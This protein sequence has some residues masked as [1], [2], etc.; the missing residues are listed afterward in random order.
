MEVNAFLISPE[1]AEAG[2]WGTFLEDARVRI[3]R[4]NSQYVREWI[5]NAGHDPA[6]ILDWLDLA[7]ADRTEEQQS[8]IV[9]LIE[10]ALMADWEGF[11]SEGASVEFGDRGLVVRDPRASA[12]RAWAVRYSIRLSPYTEAQ[13]AAVGGK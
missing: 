13:A 10:H 4:I 12:F 3:R 9:D 2:A 1:A 6:Q 11:T 8:A 5:R 7:E